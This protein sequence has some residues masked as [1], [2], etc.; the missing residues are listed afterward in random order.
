MYQQA[1]QEAWEQMLALRKE[2]ESALLDVDE[3][4]AQATA[5]KAQ[6]HI[7]RGFDLEAFINTH[8]PE[9]RTSV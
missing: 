9:L 2:Q 1:E 4:V 8:E 5:A 6:A 3:A 7:Q